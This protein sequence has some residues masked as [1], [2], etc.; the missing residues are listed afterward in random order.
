MTRMLVQV[1]PIA[2]IIGCLVVRPASPAGAQATNEP[3]TQSDSTFTV[4]CEI[5]CSDT[6]LRTVNARLRW[7]LAKAIATAGGVNAAAAKV[8]LEATVYRD[9]FNKGLFVQLPIGT[10]SPRQ[11]IV[12]ILPLGRAAQKPVRAFQI[13][14]VE[15]E[16]ARGDAVS[17]GEPVRAVVVENLE[18][19]VTYTWRLAVETT[20]GRVVSVPVTCRARPCPA[21]LIDR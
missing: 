8:T 18:P 13:Q 2:L 1:S 4:S 10:A 7:T 3:R 19:G 6:K 9:G 17:P 20:T 15:T 21:D 11:P 16:P 14:I 5:F 12:G